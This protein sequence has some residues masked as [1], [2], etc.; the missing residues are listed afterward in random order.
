MCSHTRTQVPLMAGVDGCR[1]GAFRT[2]CMGCRHPQE[3]VVF[4]GRAVD[5]DVAPASE[6][7]S[8][9]S[10]WSFNTGA[11]ALAC[12]Q[13]THHLQLPSCLPPPP[14]VFVRLCS[15]LGRAWV[16]NHAHPPPLSS[17]AP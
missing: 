3:I 2:A 16:T 7:P 13:P 12:R 6:V 8:T 11:G 10:L 4:G 17:P 5:G 14:F 15:C 1:C 9:R